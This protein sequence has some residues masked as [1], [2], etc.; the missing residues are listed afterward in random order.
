[1][2]TKLTKSNEISPANSA[3]EDLSGGSEVNRAMRGLGVHALAEKAKE[4]HLLANKPTRHTD[5]LATNDDDALP[6]EELLGDDRR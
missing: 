3:P 6:I 4:L 1:M 5:L 2:Q